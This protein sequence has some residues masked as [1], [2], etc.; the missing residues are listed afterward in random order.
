MVVVEDTLIMLI[1]LALFSSSFC[2]NWNVLQE[3]ISDFRFRIGADI[4]KVWLLSHTH[5]LLLLPPPPM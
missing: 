3:H 5:L 2:N 4:V 1:V